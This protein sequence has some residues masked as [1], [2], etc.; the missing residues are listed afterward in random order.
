MSKKNEL[1]EYGEEGLRAKSD[2]L[3][4]RVAGRK[5]GRLHGAWQGGWSA[6]YYNSVGSKEGWAPGQ[7][8]HGKGQ[9]VEDFMDD[10]DL[11]DMLKSNMRVNSKFRNTADPSATTTTATTTSSSTPLKDDTYLHSLVRPCSQYIGETL[12]RRLG[13][14][15]VAPLHKLSSK[16]SKKSSKSSKRKRN[17]DEDEDDELCRD[18]LRESLHPQEMGLIEVSDTRG[19]G[20]VAGGKMRKGRGAADDLRSMARDFKKRRLFG[21]FDDDDDDAVGESGGAGEFADYD[22]ALEINEAH[23]HSRIKSD[24]TQALLDKGYDPLEVAEATKLFSS[25]KQLYV[26]SNPP[27]ED[28]PD[29]IVTLPEHFTPRRPIEFLLYGNEQNGIMDIDMKVMS[30]LPQKQRAALV[31]EGQKVMQ[32]REQRKRNRFDEKPDVIRANPSP[33]STTTPQTTVFTPLKGSLGMRF[34]SAKRQELVKPE[35]ETEQSASGGGLINADAIAT[36]AVFGRSTE[37]SADEAMKSAAASGQYGRMTRET[38]QWYPETLLCRRLNIADPFPNTTEKGDG[39]K[40][41]A[42]ASSSLSTVFTPAPIPTEISTT[43][44]ATPTATPGS[45]AKIERNKR[46]KARREER[47]QDDFTIS[48]DVGGDANEGD[49]EGMDEDMMAAIDEIMGITHS[50]EENQNPADI[51][52]E[53]TQGDDCDNNNNTAEED[54]NADDKMDLFDSIFGGGEDVPEEPDSAP[55]T[56][57]EEEGAQSKSVSALQL[58]A[59]AQVNKGNDAM[60]KRIEMLRTLEDSSEESKESKELTKKERKKQK[61][62]E[63]KMRKKDKKEKKRA[64]KREKKEK[65]KQRK[66]NRSDSSDSDSDSSSS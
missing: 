22:D 9:R 43:I 29:N 16:S 51:P 21:G 66:R 40:G 41:K 19:L 36:A 7:R 60:R 17:E 33:A 32:Q 50:P 4:S 45:D 61:K 18:I 56:A 63:K 1:I 39:V 47:R 42:T 30:L 35:G 62:S 48:V 58:A 10:E 46:K 2:V 54:D 23:H 64:K 55:Q 27:L 26:R 53:A 13:W 38:R 14:V 37:R 44:P 31:T 15:E 8:E 65:R 49:D 11:Q 28:Q 6:G 5:E 25:W 12:L 57:E 3:G 34:T 59:A 52:D 20:Y 24:D